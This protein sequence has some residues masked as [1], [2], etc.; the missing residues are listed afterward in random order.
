MKIILTRL[1]LII[2]LVTSFS[3]LHGQITEEKRTGSGIY[4]LP[5]QLVFPE[6]LLTYE[7]F[8]KNNLSVSFSLGYKIPTGKGDTLE[9][10]GSG[11]FEGKPS[12]SRVLQ[13]LK[14]V[15]EHSK[16]FQKSWREVG[17]L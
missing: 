2:I 5:T 9:P 10:F 6:I 15:F 8:L 14:G 11:L 1:V 4:I 17:F 12:A 3:R 16:K 7:H 13:F